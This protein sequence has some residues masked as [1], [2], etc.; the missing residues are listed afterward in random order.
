MRRAVA[1][2]ILVCGTVLAQSSPDLATLEQTARK[3]H[4]EWEALA[5][6]L[7]ER[8]ARILP[9]DPR[10]AAAVT[11]VSRASETRLAALAEYF[12]AATTQAFAET[13]TAKILLNAEEKHA[14]EAGIERADTGQEQT[15][16]DTQTDALAQSLKHRT[17]L[18]D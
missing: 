10:A 8:I 14:V 7:G 9:C 13:A 12:K 15:A 18:Q 6:D 3:R 16:V 1:L 5:K 11:E 4:A 17:S 2:G